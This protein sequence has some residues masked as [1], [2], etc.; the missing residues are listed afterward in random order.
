MASSW[1]FLV[2]CLAHAE[3]LGG[4]PTLGGNMTLGSLGKLLQLLEDGLSSCDC[5]TT[6]SSLLHM[7]RIVN[8]MVNNIYHNIV[9]NLDIS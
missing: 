8:L 2:R 4:S 3:H 1:S 7:A 9:D 5:Y 6:L